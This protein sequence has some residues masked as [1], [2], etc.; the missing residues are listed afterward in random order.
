MALFI[1]SNQNQKRKN[2]K[3][4]Q[5][6]SD[7]PLWEYSSKLAEFVS[8]RVTHSFSVAVQCWTAGRQENQS[9]FTFPLPRP[10][11]LF[12]LSLSLCLFPLLF[13]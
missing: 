1:L 2:W 12:F 6:V 7:L 9:S 5:I 4:P 13:Q 11:A 10:Y 3:T 8:D